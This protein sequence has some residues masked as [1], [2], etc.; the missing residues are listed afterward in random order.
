MS[1]LSVMKLCTCFS[2]RL[3]SNLRARTA[4][5]SAVQPQPCRR[6]THRRQ[7]VSPSPAGPVL[8]VSQRCITLPG[9]A[10]ERRAAAP[11]LLSAPAAGTRRQRRQLSVDISCPQGTQ[12]Q[13]CRCC[14]QTMGQTDGQTS[15]RYID[16]VPHSTRASSNNSSATLSVQLCVQY[17]HLFSGAFP[18]PPG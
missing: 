11:L 1:W 6:H 14:R 15:D 2:A 3:N 9:F 13:T 8:S 5:T 10:A 18:G 17:T 12:Q 4:T 16:P 7:P